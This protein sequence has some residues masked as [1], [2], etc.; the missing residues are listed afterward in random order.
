MVEFMMYQKITKSDVKSAKKKQYKKR[1]K[2]VAARY[3]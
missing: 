1:N 3:L 2:R